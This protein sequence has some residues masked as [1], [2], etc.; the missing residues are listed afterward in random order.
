MGAL[1]SSEYNGV[2]TGWPPFDRTKVR[3][4]GLLGSARHSYRP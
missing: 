1:S 2:G 4:H 3:E